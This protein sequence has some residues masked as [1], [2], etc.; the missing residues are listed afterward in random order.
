M[1]HIQ[2]GEFLGQV[3]NSLNPLDMEIRHHHDEMNGKEV[4]ALVRLRMG[5][6]A[7]AAN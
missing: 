4:Y 6:T 3:N 7:E 5:H 1:P 2:F